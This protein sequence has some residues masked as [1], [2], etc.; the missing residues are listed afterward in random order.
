MFKTITKGALVLLAG[1]LIGT[2]LLWL[3]YLLPVT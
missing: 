3:S 2:T 1:L